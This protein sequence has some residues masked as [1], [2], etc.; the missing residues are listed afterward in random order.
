MRASNGVILITTKKGQAGSSS[1]EYEGYAGFS[2]P[3]NT[4]D[5]LQAWQFMEITNENNIMRGSMPPGKFIYP[6]DEIEKFK[7]GKRSARSGTE[8]TTTNTLLNFSYDFYERGNDKILYF[9]NFA[10]FSQNSI[11]STRDL[12]YERFNLRS[13]ISVK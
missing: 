10:Y 6:L 13:N 4:P 7:S 11:Y 8:L 12:T 1:I 2:T 3:I 5:G 9:T